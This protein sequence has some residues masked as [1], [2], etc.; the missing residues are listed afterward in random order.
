MCRA[1]CSPNILYCYLQAGRV[2][3][4]RLYSG[5]Y[6][7]LFRKNHLS[8]LRKLNSICNAKSTSTPALVSHVH[9]HTSARARRWTTL[10][11]SIIISGEV[12][13][14]KAGGALHASRRAAATRMAAGA[15]GGTHQRLSSERG[16]GQ[17]SRSVCS[18]SRSAGDAACV[19]RP[20]THAHSHLVTSA[21]SL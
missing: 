10:I 12:C 2:P 7:S 3:R 5:H 21:L 14:R 20:A 6:R 9:A 18:A 8:I 16:S 17:A 4:W 19:P 11:Y 1:S 15:G 13:I